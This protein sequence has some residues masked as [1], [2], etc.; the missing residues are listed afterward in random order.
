MEKRVIIVNG[1]GGVGKDTICAL[2]AACYR[3]RNISSI[4]PIVRIARFGGWDG[5]KT[6]ASRLLL[7]RL[8]TAFTEFSDLSFSYCM[9]QYVAFL[10]GDERVLF[11]H[12][13]EPEEIAR[14]RDAV[15]PACRT[16]LVRRSALEA[17]GPLG[18][19]SDDNVDEYQYDYYFDND[20]PLDRLGASV[21][22]FFRLVL[23]GEPDETVRWHFR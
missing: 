3:T 12:I 13:R 9:Q 8:K 14:F 4:E 10:E 7:S 19:R 5:V 20:G 6:P 22:D 2:A 11:V 18:N 15:G 23:D 21:R 1:R 16:L 17:E